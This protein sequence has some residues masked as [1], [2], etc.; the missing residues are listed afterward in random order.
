MAKIAKKSI[1][2][3]PSDS[4]DVVTN[5]LY[6]EEAPNPVTYD[7]QFVDV[8][9]T[10]DGDG[11]IVV[12]LGVHFVGMDGVYNI[13]VAAVDD[14]GNEADMQ[15]ANDLPLDFQAPNPTGAIEIL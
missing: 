6:F 5:R 7:S 4:P 9:N 3:L 8:G 11:Y 1:R 12:D 10:P 2:F 13:G 15:E 14:G